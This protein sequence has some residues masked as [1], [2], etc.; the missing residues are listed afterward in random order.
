MHPL[1][2][3]IQNFGR[4]PMAATD[5]STSATPVPIASGKKLRLGSLT[6]LVIGSMVGSGVFSLPQNMAA[7]AGPLA[8]IIG[9]GITA[10]GMLA[11]VFVYQSL[12]TRKP[13]LDAGPYAYAKAGFGRLS[14]STAPGVTG[15]APGSATFPMRSSCSVRCP[16]SSR[17]LATATPGKP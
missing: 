16:I 1:L 4:F 8:I 13:T 5:I 10:V 14:A 2:E 9:W 3:M 12:A 7:G 15:S 6:A 17:P 11:L